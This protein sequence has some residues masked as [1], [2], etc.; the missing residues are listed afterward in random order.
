MVP[1]TRSRKQQHLAHKRSLGAAGRQSS[2]SQRKP[3]GR[4]AD[5]TGQVVAGSSEKD[6]LAVSGPAPKLFDRES[7]KTISVKEAA[8]R[9]KKSHDTIYRWLR[10]GRLQ[11]WQLGG[12]GCSILVREDSVTVALLRS[13]GREGPASR[14]Q[15]ELCS[16][17]AGPGC[18]A[19]RAAM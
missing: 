19:G 13:L 4:A 16:S 10:S 3:V 1:P 5:A 14:K 18:S 7:E 2:P 6:R 11:G 17:V 9:L 15:P 8:F 12:S